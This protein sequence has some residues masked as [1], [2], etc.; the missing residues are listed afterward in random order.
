MKQR[1]VLL[2][3]GDVLKCALAWDPD[4]CMIGNVTAREVAHLA[5]ESIEHNQG[6]C[7]AC[8][9]ERGVNIDCPVCEI[10]DELIRSEIQR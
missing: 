8:G 5:A 4:V 1:G 6:A 10:W 3:A 9:A 2:I 7:P